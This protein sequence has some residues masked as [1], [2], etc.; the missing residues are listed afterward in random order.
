MRLRSRLRPKP[1]WGAYSAP[2]TPSR[3]WG[4]SLLLPQNPKPR[5]RSRSSAS[6][7]GP[8]S[9]AAF[10]GWWPAR[11]GDRRPCTGQDNL[12]GPV[13]HVASRDTVAGC[14][15]VLDTIQ[16]DTIVEFN[17]DVVGYVS[18]IVEGL[19]VEMVDWPMKLIMVFWH[20]WDWCL[21]Y[22]QLSS[23]SFSVIFPPDDDVS[24]CCWASAL[25]CSLLG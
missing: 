21:R 19:L 2:Q 25:P 1:R 24:C 3:W 10:G 9:L 8:S 12:S 14:R 22:M 11:W 4:G 17:V 5:S 13:N 20:R 16:Y 18:S 23:I 15:P 6:H 7:F